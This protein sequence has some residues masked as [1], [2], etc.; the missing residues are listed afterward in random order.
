MSRIGPCLCGDPECPS[1]GPLQGYSKPRPP[2][3]IIVADEDGTVCL[4]LWTDEKY[5]DIYDVVANRLSV[6]DTK[7]ELDEANEPDEPQDMTDVEAD[8]DTLKSAG[9]GTDEDYGFFGDD[10]EA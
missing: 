1:C 5:E 7:E 2:F 9:Y 3:H 10:N 8:A 4:E 6:Y